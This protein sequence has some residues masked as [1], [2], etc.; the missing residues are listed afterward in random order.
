[1]NGKLDARASPS[2]LTNLTRRLSAIKQRTILESE[3]LIYVNE[4]T[5]TSAHALGVVIGLPT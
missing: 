4:L 2:S 3:E 5:H 1:M